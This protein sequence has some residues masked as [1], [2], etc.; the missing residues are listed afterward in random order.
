MGRYMPGVPD[1]L[2]AST[3]KPNEKKTNRTCS[4]DHFNGIAYHQFNR[5]GFS[6]R[7]QFRSLAAFT[8]IPLHY[9]KMLL[10]FTGKFVRIT[11]HRI[12]WAAVK[13]KQNGV[14]IV[15]SFDAYPLSDPTDRYRF[16]PVNGRRHS[17]SKASRL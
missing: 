4:R 11:H 1:N 14:S 12:T 17:L 13:K 2:L 5:E 7:I 3:K 10:Q 15:R 6:R 9:D 8:L 16:L